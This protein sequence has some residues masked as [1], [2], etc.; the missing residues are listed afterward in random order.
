MELVI[1]NIRTLE[2]SNV[3]ETAMVGHK[4]GYFP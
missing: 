3:D 1:L 4:R 2:G